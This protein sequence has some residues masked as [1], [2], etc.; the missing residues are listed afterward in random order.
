MRISRTKHDDSSRELIGLLL[1]NT[2]DGE[3]CR[4]KK[5]R[6]GACQLFITLRST[7]LC[8]RDIACLV[9]CVMLR[10]RDSARVEVL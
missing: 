4:F 9:A 2:V 10:D 1:G 3:P 6:R 5:I 8:L 7:S